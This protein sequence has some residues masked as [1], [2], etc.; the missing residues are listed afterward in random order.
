M[1]PDVVTILR[2][3]VVITQPAGSEIL[4][5]MAVAAS[6]ANGD[7]AEA[8]LAAISDIATGAPDA[9]SVLNKLNASSVNSL[10]D[11]PFYGVGNGV[12]DD[13]AAVLAANAAGGVVYVPEGR[14]ETTLGFYD[15][16]NFRLT[17]EGQAKL[18]GYA[19]ARD[20]AFI[21][22]EVADS[23]DDRV[24]A[25]DGDWSKAHSLRYTFVGSSVGASPISE[26]RTLTR[27]AMSFD[28]YDFTGGRQSDPGDHTAGRTGAIA[29]IL[30]L[31]H[32]GQGD[33]VGY[34][35]HGEVYS[36]RAGATHFLANPAAV[37]ENG[38]FTA[39][40]AGTGAYLN[41]SEYI[42]T[43]NGLAVAVVDRVRNY[44]RSND[45]RT[46]SQRWVHDRPQSTG[47]K[48][49]DAAYNPAGSFRRLYDA[50]AADLTA[51]MAAITLLTGQRIYG[52]ATTIADSEGARWEADTV[53]DDYLTFEDGGWKVG[54][55][56]SAEIL[57]PTA[58]TSLTL[59][60]S[61]VAEGGDYG[62]PKYRRSGSRICLSG[63]AKAGTNF[64][65]IAQLPAGF[66]PANKTTFAT[67]T[68]FGLTQIQIWPGGEVVATGV[69]NSGGVNYCGLDGVTFDPA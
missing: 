32:G 62:A 2:N 57:K 43:D 65:V 60:N 6:A 41:H 59:Q 49:V 48:P 18:G 34:Q 46:I 55:G 38:G 7:R 52:N 42:Y 56:G 1:T 24:Q 31:Y 5:A 64:T 51:D 15:L 28:V 63:V 10:K 53:G 12:A 3:N 19:Q 67:S 50:T 29:H 47:S 37:K 8:A 39:S 66:R 58:L 11:Q 17:G 69:Q 9:P 14:Y 54:V 26:Y 13:T 68:A 35:F 22:S 21:T 4:V 30:R 44:I 45:G 61:W 23:P 16:L 36:A 33:C 40:A 25:F 20:R 27:A